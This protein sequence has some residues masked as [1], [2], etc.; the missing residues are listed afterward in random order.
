MISKKPF[1]LKFFAPW[2]THCQ[3]LAPVWEELYIKHQEFL[4]VLKVDCT[5][6]DGRDLCIQFKVKG[7]PTVIYLQDSHFFK[8]KGDRTIDSF[9]KFVFEEGYKDAELQGPI[10]LKVV[11]P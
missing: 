11:N 8:Y 10:P 9:E 7:Y 2:C 4:N 5:D 3:E 6:E 1:L